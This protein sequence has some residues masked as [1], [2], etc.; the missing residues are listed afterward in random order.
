MS[1]KTRVFC[2]FL[3]VVCVGFSLVSCSEKAV[4]SCGARSVDARLFRYALTLTKTKTLSTLLGSSQNLV[5]DAQYWTTDLGDST[6]YGDLVVENTL[7]TLKM[8]LF[9]SNYADEKGLSLSAEEQALAQENVQKILSSFDSRAAFDDYMGSYGFDYS[10]IERYYELDAL[11]Q[12]GMRAYYSHPSTALTQADVRA[13]FE[14]HYATVVYLYVNETDTVLSNGK[15]VPLTAEQKEERAAF[16]DAAAQSVRSAE[17]FKTFNQKT[18]DALFA[19]GKPQTLLISSLKTEK[20]Q[21]AART[22]QE[23]SSTVVQAERGRFLLWKEPLDEA[24]LTE[25]SDALLL[26][27]ISEREEEILKQEEDSFTLDSAFIDSLD[28]ATLPIF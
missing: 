8:T 5:D 7:K 21:E 13:Y 11:S 23:G 9:Y 18:D 26:S 16:F 20:L 27:L 6:T 22:L 12:A 1:L 28:V 3:A 25:Y 4:L 24:F 2:L 10:L 17:D 15:R 19:D 14:A